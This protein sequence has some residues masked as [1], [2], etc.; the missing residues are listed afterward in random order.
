MGNYI[1]YHYLKTELSNIEKFFIFIYKIG[2]LHDSAI[3]IPKRGLTSFPQ[4]R[5]LTVRLFIPQCLTA[6]L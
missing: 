6:A 2:P 5:V 4:W 1:I 3:L